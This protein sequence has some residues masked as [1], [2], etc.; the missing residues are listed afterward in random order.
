MRFF[1]LRAVGVC[2]LVLFTIALSGNTALAQTVTTSPTSS[3]FGVPHGS[4]VS[5]E[6]LITITLTGGG[7][8][9]LTGFST[10]ANTDFAITSNTC[11][12]APST[13]SS[14]G[15]CKVGITFTPLAP[16]GT[17]ESGSLTF[18]ASASDGGITV[19]L[20]GALGA[21]KIF[22]ELD[23]ATSTPPGIYLSN[24]VTYGS[25]T[26]NLS[27][28]VDG[29]TGILSNAP[30]NSETFP[31]HLLEDNYLVLSISGT[32]VDNGGAPAGNVCPGPL[33]DQNGNLQQKDCFTSFYQNNAANLLGRNTD[34][35]TNANDIVGGPGGVPA[36]DIS[37]FLGFGT[38]TNGTP[39]SFTLLD[40]G[41]DVAGSTVFLQ[42][43]C[44]T[45]G[46]IQPGGSITG[47]PVNPNI[48]ASLTPQFAFSTT[49]GNNVVFLADYTGTAGSENAT[50]A[51]TVTDVGIRQSAF[52]AFVAGTHAGPAVCLRLTAEV[53]P[54]SHEVLCK[55][56]LI[57]CTTIGDS[58]PSG[59]NCP[60]SAA[61]NLKFQAKFDSLD[62]PIPTAMNGYSNFL[63]DGTNHTGSACSNIATPAGAL[64][65]H[66][67]GPALLEGPDNWVSAATCSFP[68]SDPLNGSACPQNPLTAFRGA[69][70]PGHTVTTKNTN[71]LFVPVVNMPLPTD[72]VAVTGQNGNGWV[73][74]NSV[75]VKITAN[76]AAYSPT[77]NN[78][79]SNGFTPVGIFTE[80]YGTAPISNPVPDPDGG[81]VAGDTTATNGACPTIA[82]TPFVVT[83]TLSLSDGIYNLHHFP[84]DCA[85]TEG[86]LFQPNL[87]Q[88]QTASANW[89]AFP[90]KVIG[91]DHVAPTL[92]SC[93][94]PPS[95]GPGGRYTSNITIHCT[96]TDQGYSAG[97]SGSGFTP[98][99]ANSIQGSPSTVVALSTNVT[100]G[101]YNPA[102]LTNSPSVCD[103]AGNCVTVPALGPFAIDL[104]GSADLALAAG[105]LPPATVKSGTLI[106]YGVIAT[107]YG[108][109][110]AQ[111][112]SITDTL[113]AGATFSGGFILNGFSFANCTASGGVVTCPVGNLNKGGGVL[114]FITIKVPST[115]GTIT[116]TIA[117][118]GLNPDPKPAN[119]SFTVK[120]TVK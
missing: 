29:V 94:A 61:D 106:T 34:S 80:I 70:D 83:D 27:C 73:N 89:A 63:P 56:F 50:A 42:T 36:I 17:L 51:P 68:P 92:T 110:S 33:A 100:A 72:T 82:A 44:T 43:N 49:P 35:I 15:S 2:L 38:S 3:A 14:P 40:G 67:T 55:G 64:C 102:A 107:N 13:L 47:N 99:L 116:N 16:E 21:I 20:T 75:P 4:T 9:T 77:A 31:G 113:P 28:P 115:P 5:A 97:V 118:G 103:L 30:A 6:Q 53:D 32:P 88:L 46:T 19:A 78:P 119:N 74:T 96:V 108:P 58:T 76:A 26:V 87:V 120:T 101:T 104:L 1:D 65:A 11:P 71:S 23:V 69:E 48:P 12:V 90:V 59:S 7:T 22:D 52:A 98:L 112:V 24:S 95:P 37:S 62:A 93:D 105:S 91:V 81:P 109:S 66:G 85:N 39:V 86:L 60:Q 45:P 79:I 111:G 8:T 54:M 114:A 25:R 57:E 18:S 84:T 41:G 117:I 10:S